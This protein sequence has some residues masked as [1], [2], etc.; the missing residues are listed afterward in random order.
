MHSSSQVL[1]MEWEDGCGHRE[2]PGIARCEWQG[3]VRC[4]VVW[5]VMEVLHLN[6]L[7]WVVRVL[8]SGEFV[9]PIYPA[10]W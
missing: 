6:A 5:W 7:H 1:G 4:G 9:K 3:V 10:S 8:V 2:W